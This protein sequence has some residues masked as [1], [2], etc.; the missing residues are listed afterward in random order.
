MTPL[1]LFGRPQITVTGT[2]FLV[3][4]DV[5]W[6]TNEARLDP[7][8]GNVASILQLDENLN[9]SYITFEAAAQV[10]CSFLL[11]LVPPSSFSASNRLTNVLRGIC[12]I[13]EAFPQRARRCSISFDHALLWG[14]TDGAR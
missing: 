14:E 11:Y 6:I 13:R 8:C 4:F 7:R 12:R 1:S 9:S 3:L 2:Y 5:V 10:R